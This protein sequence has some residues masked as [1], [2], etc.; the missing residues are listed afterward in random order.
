MPIFT[1]LGQDLTNLAHKRRVIF[2]ILSSWGSDIISM[3]KILTLWSPHKLLE[4]L[5]ALSEYA[6]SSQCLKIDIL[7]LY[8]GYDGMVQETSHATV[9][10]MKTIK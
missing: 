1:E 10:L 9:P 7:T 4:N 5:G 8:P 6:K 3:V 2:S